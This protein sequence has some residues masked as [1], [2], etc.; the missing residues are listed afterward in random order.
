MTSNHGEP[1]QVAASTEVQKLSLAYTLGL[2]AV[3]CLLVAGQIVVQQMLVHQERDAATINVAGRQRMLSQKLVKNTLLL[4]A[5]EDTQ[6]TDSVISTMADDLNE[7]RTAHRQLRSGFAGPD[8]AIQSRRRV[9][10]LF[11]DLELHFQLIDDAATDI[12]DVGR[13]TRAASL[14]ISRQSAVIAAH[15]GSYLTVMDRIVQVFESEAR[16]RVRRLRRTLNG[17]AIAIFAVLL[18]QALLIFRP[19]VR[20]VHRTVLDLAQSREAAE[21]LSLQDELCGVPNRRRFEHE[22]PREWQRALRNGSPVSII[23]IDLDKFKALNDSAG[24]ETG[25]DCLV[26]VASTLNAEMRR[27]TDLVARYGGDEFVVILP[28]TDEPGA[29]SVADRL[30]KSIEALEISL[31]NETKIGITTG[32]ATGNP[33]HRDVDPHDLVAEADRRMLQAKGAREIRELPVVEQ[34]GQLAALGAATERERAGLFRG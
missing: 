14:S 16:D 30:R 27:S 19:L 4:R 28:D 8:S 18:I 2:L 7:W 33:S 31:G 23:M 6:I 29:L 5:S 34:R 32:V 22:L 24:H 13:Q 25:D 17:L 9:E 3:V 12:I 10:T 21:T 20:R 1:L 26:R 11:D 15:E